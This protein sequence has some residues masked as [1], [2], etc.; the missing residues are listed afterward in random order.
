MKKLALLIIIVAVFAFEQIG[1]AKEPVE[2]TEEFFSM[3]SAGKISKAYDQLFV[4]SQIPAQKP[5]AVDMLKRQTSSGLPLYGKI[6][7]FEKIRDERIGR[8]IVRLVYVLKLE[9]SP[10]TW[11]FYFYKPKDRWFLVKVNFNDQFQ[12]LHKME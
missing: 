8:S 4:G 2:F 6:V 5:Q 11:E 12:L 9:L 7:G 3:V 10:T 1:Y